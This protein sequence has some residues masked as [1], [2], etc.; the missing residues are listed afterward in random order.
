MQEDVIG[1][2][3]E[4]ISGTSSL[5]VPVM[6]SGKRIGETP[7]LEEIRA[8]TNAQ[9]SALPSEMKTLRGPATYSVRM[10]DQ[11]LNLQNQLLGELGQQTQWRTLISRDLP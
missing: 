5:L 8:R 7:S 3:D 11:L 10:S 6:Q 9:L 4:H 2:R 1:L